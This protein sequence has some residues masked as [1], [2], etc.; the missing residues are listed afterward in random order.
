MQFAIASAVLNPWPISD[1]PACSSLNLLSGPD[2]VLF[3]LGVLW[4][5][6]SFTSVTESLVRQLGAALSDCV[7]WRRDIA[8]ILSP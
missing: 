2:L 5:Y 8:G 6:P 4:I 1:Y 7:C 3:I